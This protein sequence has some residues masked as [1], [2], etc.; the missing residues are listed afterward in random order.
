MP[1]LQKFPY[2]IEGG[3]DLIERTAQ[4]YKKIGTNLLNDKDGSIVAH[5][6]M[7]HHHKPVPIITE[8]YERWIRSSPDH[9]W[10]RLVQCW[11]SFDHAV[12]ATEIEAVLTTE[13]QGNC[14]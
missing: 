2:L 1:A 10:K 8:I 5:I 4:Q 7:A 9:S 6:E 12:L 13:N 11:T 14:Y 3:N